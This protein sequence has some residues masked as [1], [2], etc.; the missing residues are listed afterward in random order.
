M[1]FARQL[2]EIGKGESVNSENVRENEKMTKIQTCRS[3][4]V[5]M[6]FGKKGK[7]NIEKGNRDG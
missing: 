4:T 2:N 1:A 7:G 6:S 5:L 3:L